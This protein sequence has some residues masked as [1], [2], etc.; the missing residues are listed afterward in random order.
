MIPLDG[1]V[2]D[3]ECTVNQ[4]SMTGES[5]PVLKKSG[6]YVYAGTVIEEGQI[7]IQVRQTTGDTR[8]EKI[9]TMIEQSEKLKSA[10]ESR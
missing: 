5:E 8:Y 6:S 9:I 4:S 7:K 3:G 10:A 1:T 2:T